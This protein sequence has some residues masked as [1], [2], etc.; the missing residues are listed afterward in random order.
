MQQV[1]SKGRICSFCGKEWGLLCVQ[2]VV[3]EVEPGGA[4]GAIS[5]ICFVT[6]RLQKPSTMHGYMMPWTMCHELADNAQK[7]GPTLQVR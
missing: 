6:C 5:H 7:S 4:V 3:Q 2:A 1:A